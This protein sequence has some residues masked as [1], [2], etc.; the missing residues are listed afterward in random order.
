MMAQ[1]LSISVSLIRRHRIDD[2]GML[3]LSPET[4]RHY[5]R[6]I[7]RF[8]TLRWRSPHTATVQEVRRFQIEQQDVDVP[9]PATSDIVSALCFFIH[10]LNRPTP[11]AS[12]CVLVKSTKFRW[13]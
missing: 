6:D 2:I 8:A 10:T 11:P 4:K 7:G 13:S 1:S 12:W 3:R 5:I 9:A